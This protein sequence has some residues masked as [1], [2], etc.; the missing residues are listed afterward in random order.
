MHS[1]FVQLLSL[2]NTALRL[3]VPVGCSKPWLLEIAK[4]QSFPWMDTFVILSPDDEIGVVA[5][6]V[7]T[8]KLPGHS[9]L[10]LS[11]YFSWVHT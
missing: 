4:W 3:I 7:I 2:S 1:F 8:T 10:S 6:L 5:F 9:R 11:V